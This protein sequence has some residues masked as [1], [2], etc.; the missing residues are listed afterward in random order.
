MAEFALEDDLIALEELI[1]TLRQSVSL[2]ARELL[3]RVLNRLREQQRTI[4]LLSDDTEV[5]A[6]LAG[7]ADM[8]AGRVRQI[9]NS[10]YGTTDGVTWMRLPKGTMIHIHGIP[11]WVDRRARVLTSAGNVR[12]IADAIAQPEAP[13]T[14]AQQAASEE[15][16][17]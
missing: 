8:K 14:G 17:R 6:L 1:N 4:E 12:L 3:Y 2:D 10:D 16:Q 7:L 9:R 5:Q 11:C 15:R 13:H